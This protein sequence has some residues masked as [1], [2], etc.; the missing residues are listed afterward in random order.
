MDQLK[1]EKQKFLLQKKKYALKN[2]FWEE[3]CYGTTAEYTTFELLNRSYP[4]F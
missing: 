3:A 1:K 4:E 2:Y